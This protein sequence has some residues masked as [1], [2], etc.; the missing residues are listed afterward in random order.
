MTFT[1]KMV[2]NCVWCYN[3]KYVICMFVTNFRRNIIRAIIN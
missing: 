1:V 3:L 2:I